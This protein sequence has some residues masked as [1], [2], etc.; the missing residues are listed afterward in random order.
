MK[1]YKITFLLFLFGLSV[2]FYPKIYKYFGITYSNANREIFEKS[3][4]YI[5]GKIENLQR[6]KLEYEI[7]DDIEHKKAI[8]Y[9]ILVESST[10]TDLNIPK[11]L[12]IFIDNL[13]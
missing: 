5:H 7:T 12:K 3:K 4:S 1:I 10:I 9:M 13:K 6:L 11:D 2:V 8:R